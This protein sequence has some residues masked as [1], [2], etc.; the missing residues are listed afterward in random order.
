MYVCTNN[1]NNHNTKRLKNFLEHKSI[2]LILSDLSR[3]EYKQFVFFAERR[4]R[5]RKSSRIEN[6]DFCKLEKWI[7]N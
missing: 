3:T 7:N 1:G 5:K 6:V 2:L 4:R